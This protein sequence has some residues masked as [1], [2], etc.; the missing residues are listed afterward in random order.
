MAAAKKT[1]AKKTAKKTTAKKASSS[2]K[3]ADRVNVGADATRA[4]NDTQPAQ[5]VVVTEGKKDDNQLVSNE[6]AL[7]SPSSAALN[8]AFY[9][10]PG[11]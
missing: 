1:A 5:G 8:P 11:E 4:E 9:P 10:K 2:A 6:H 7:G 3:K